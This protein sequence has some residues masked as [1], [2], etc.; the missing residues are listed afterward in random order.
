MYLKK[1]GK[2]IYL[3]FLII[4]LLTAEDGTAA[5]AKQLD[6]IQYTTEKH[7]IVLYFPK[8]LINSFLNIIISLNV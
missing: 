3:N 5:N 6:P 1:T 8:I 7:I 2:V 4:Q